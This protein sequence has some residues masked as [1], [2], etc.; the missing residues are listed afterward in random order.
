V[1]SVLLETLKVRTNLLP[2][3]FFNILAHSHFIFSAK[4]P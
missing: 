4:T 3:S 2:P 1:L